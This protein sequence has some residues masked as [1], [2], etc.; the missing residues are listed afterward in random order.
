MATVA[1][2]QVVSCLGIAVTCVCMMGLVNVVGVVRLSRCLAVCGSV[3][4]MV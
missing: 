2:E 1:D 4:V 3:V